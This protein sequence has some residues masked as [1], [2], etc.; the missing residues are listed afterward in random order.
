MLIIL[1]V[2]W[3]CKPIKQEKAKSDFQ[4]GKVYYTET[5]ASPL[6]T[7]TIYIPVQQ[8]PNNVIPDSVFFKGREA[9]LQLE[10]NLVYKGQ[11][12]PSAT[13]KTDIV[14]SSNP[15]A[16]FGNMKPAKANK[17]FPDLTNTECVVSYKEESKTQYI[18]VTGVKK[19]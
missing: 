5:S 10:S 19:Q 18:K 1:S 6:T 7:I 8:L 2:F 16:E 3:G 11:L 17:R 4:I 14:M 13:N 15:N 9:K 12:L